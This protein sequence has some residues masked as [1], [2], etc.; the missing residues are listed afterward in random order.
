MTEL[1]RVTFERDWW[2]RTVRDDLR[3]RYFSEGRVDKEIR[4]LARAMKKEWE[5]S[6][7]GEGK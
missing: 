4:K 3:M 2:K 6:Q 1:D 7:G 5:V